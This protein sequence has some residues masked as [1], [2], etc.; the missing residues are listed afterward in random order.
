VLVHDRGE[1][2]LGAGM[3]AGFPAGATAH[4]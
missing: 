2:V 3:C 1:T 4:R